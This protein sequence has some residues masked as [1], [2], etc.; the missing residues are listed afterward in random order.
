MTRG[1]KTTE[2]AW[3]Y[4]PS[5]SHTTGTAAHVVCRQN[6]NYLDKEALAFTPMTYVCGGDQIIFCFHEH[7]RDIQGYVNDYM[8]E[9]CPNLVVSSLPDPGWLAPSI[10]DTQKTDRLQRPMHRW[11]KQCRV[12]RPLLLR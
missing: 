12:R 4:R 8:L 3:R 9:D 7:G 1:T 11:R 6:V 5:C 10:R 2:C